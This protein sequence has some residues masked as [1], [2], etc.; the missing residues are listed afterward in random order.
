MH[1]QTI[2]FQSS[3]SSYDDVRGLVARLFA[4]VRRHVGL[5]SSAEPGD[6]SIGVGRLTMWSWATSTVSPSRP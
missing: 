1:C 3:V 6:A 5:E 2:W 4:Q